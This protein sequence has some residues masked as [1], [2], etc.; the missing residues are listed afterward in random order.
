M[1]SNSQVD[2]LT[3]IQLKSWQSITR[4]HNQFLVTAAGSRL[5]SVT[6]CYK[7]IVVVYSTHEMKLSRYSN[8]RKSENIS[9]KTGTFWEVRI[10]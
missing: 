6:D 2:H 7:S 10:F 5:M 1:F 3:R 8:K 9:V 4:V